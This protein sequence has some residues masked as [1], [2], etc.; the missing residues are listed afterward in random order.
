MRRLPAALASSW[1]RK[2]GLGKVYMSVWLLDLFSYNWTRRA[3]KVRELAVQSAVLLRCYQT[4]TLWCYRASR[5][6]YC[7]ISRL[8]YCRTSR[9]K[10]C[11][12]FRLRYCRT[13]TMYCCRISRLMFCQTFRLWC[14]WTSRLRCCS[15]FRLRCCRTSRLSVARHPDWGVV[16]HPG[17]G[18]V[19]HPNRGVIGHPEWSVVGHPGCGFV[20]FQVE[21]LSDLSCWTSMWWCYR[22]PDW[23]VVWQLTARLCCHLTSRL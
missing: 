12:I 21:V 4:S 7:W 20:N 10:C 13:S 23:I 17:C 1:E 5:L 6:K 15:T 9:L 2:R 11:W 22:H 18:V 3:I 8:W 19:E 16:R 14:C